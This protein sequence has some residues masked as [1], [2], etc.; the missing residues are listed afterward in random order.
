ML[1]LTA[2]L[3][4]PTFSYSFGLSQWLAKHSL[5][6]SCAFALHSLTDRWEIAGQSQNPRIQRMKA[7]VQRMLS[8]CTANTQRTLSECR[9]IAERMNCE[10]H[11]HL[12]F[13]AIQNSG[14]DQIWPP[15]S[16]AFVCERQRTSANAE[17]MLNYYWAN[18]CEFGGIWQI[19]KRFAFVN[20]Y[21]FKWDRVLTFCVLNKRLRYCSSLHC[22]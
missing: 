14:S 3:K 13:W 4:V 11:S 21:S 19:C 12:N 8:E 1:W 7:S 20:G 10:C 2:Q 15:R 6:I 9:A 16:V 22:C 18:W 17:R 5:C